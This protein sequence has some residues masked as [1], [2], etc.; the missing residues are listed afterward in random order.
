MHSVHNRDFIADAGRY[1]DTGS[2]QFRELNVG[3]NLLAQGCLPLLPYP[4]VGA[5]R[6]S[7]NHAEYLAEC[8]RKEICPTCH[9]PLVK[10]HGT[11][12]FKDGVFCSLTCEATWRGEEV[13]RRHL[14]KLK[15]DGKRHD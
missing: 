6:M 1:A 12:Q 7:E 9:G 11:G 15:Q 10:K 2:G 14:A 3:L 13:R 5:M 8:L 4:G